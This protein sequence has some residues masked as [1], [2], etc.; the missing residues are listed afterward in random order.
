KRQVLVEYERTSIADAPTIQMRHMTAENPGVDLIE[1]HGLSQLQLHARARKQTPLGF[2]PGAP[3]RHI[4][5]LR[6]PAGPELSTGQIGA[7]Q[8]VHAGPRPPLYGVRHVPSAT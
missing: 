8:G 7:C 5:D 3:S 2:D 1:R 4:D 6:R